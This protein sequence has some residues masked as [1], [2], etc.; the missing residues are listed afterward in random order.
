MESL[1]LSKTQGSPSAVSSD[2]ADWVDAYGDYLYR[3]ALGQVHAA[4]LA[5]DL[6]QETFLAALKARDHFAGQGSERTWLTGILKHKIADHFRKASRERTVDFDPMLPWEEEHLF[7][8]TGSWKG[9]WESG[10][11]PTEWDR[12]PE[13]MVEQQ[14]FWRVLEHSL[15]ALPPRMARAFWM[16]EVEGLSGEEI[17]KAL[18]ISSTNLWVMLHR[19]RMQLRRSLDV[20]WFGKR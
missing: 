12:N 3:Y 8:T 5:Q 4:D 11:G 1:S 17:C 10:K 19:A 13:E 9:H 6:V 2:P 15:A 16:R 7:Q 14:E 20:Q 18:E